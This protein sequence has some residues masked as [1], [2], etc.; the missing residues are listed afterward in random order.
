MGFQLHAPYTVC[1]SEDVAFLPGGLKRMASVFVDHPNVCIYHFMDFALFGVTQKTVKR[2][3]TL[4][5]MLW[6][7]YMEDCDYHYR[8][9]LAGCQNFYQGK[10][11]PFVTHGDEAS[12]KGA[13]TQRFFRHVKML[14]TKGKHPTRGNHA[15]L[16]KKWG[17]TKVKDRASEGQK[18]RGRKGETSVCTEMHHAMALSQ[19]RTMY[20]QA[21][22]TMSMLDVPYGEKS[23]SIKHWK[24]EGWRT[25]KSC[26]A[27]RAVNVQHAPADFAWSA[28]D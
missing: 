13:V 19:E 22:A 17:P 2:I 20:L 18:R 7:A 11:A 1:A 3:G 26:V 27:S 6:P 12:G 15:Y 14:V 28:Q 10:G 16:L 24:L 25:S 9:Q 4:D 5:E 21:S 23:L 8:S